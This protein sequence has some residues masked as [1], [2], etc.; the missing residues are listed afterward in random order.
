MAS[1]SDSLFQIL[2]DEES[3]FSS[4]TFDNPNQQVSNLLRRMCDLGFGQLD[5]SFLSLPIAIFSDFSLPTLRGTL[6]LKL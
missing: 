3:A 1:F 6:I 2:Y 4:L 5:A